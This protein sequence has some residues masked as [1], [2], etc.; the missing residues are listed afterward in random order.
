MPPQVQALLLETPLDEV[1]QEILPLLELC[2][3][4]LTRALDVAQ[5]RG[6]AGWSDAEYRSLRGIGQAQWLLVEAQAK[7][8]PF[9]RVARRK[10]G[11][12]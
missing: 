1:D 11:N 4:V 8:R 2:E 9:P 3:A 10:K 7:G 12:A 6:A 5:K